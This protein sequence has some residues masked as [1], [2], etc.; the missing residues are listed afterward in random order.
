M[1]DLAYR[2]VYAMNRVQARQLLLQTYEQTKSIRATARLWHTSRQ[3][4]RKWLRAFHIQT[5]VSFQRDWGQ[6][7]SGDN[8]AHLATLSARSC[9]PSKANYS[10]IPLGVKLTTA[11]SNAAIARTTMN[12]TSREP[13]P[14]TA[15]S[16]C[17]LKPGASLLLQRT[18]TF[19]PRLPNTFCP[20]QGA[21]A[22]DR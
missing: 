10:A 14:F 3:V 5:P 7:F 22:R 16:T 1:A 21:S 6:E 9:S 17:S 18:R 8:P 12:S 13:L 11:A 20:P 2:E 19:L 4:V 15:S